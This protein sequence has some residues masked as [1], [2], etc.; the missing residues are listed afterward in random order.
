MSTRI[1]VLIPCK[2]ERLNIRPCIASAASLA[3]E[4]LIADAGSTDGTLDIVRDVGG[5]RIIERDYLHAADFKNWAIPQAT[6]QWVLLVDADERITPQLAAEIRRTLG[7]TSGEVDA[8]LVRRL[9]HYLG[10]RIRRCG[11]ERDRVIRLF[12]RDACRYQPRWVHAEIDIDRKRVRR[13]REPML[14]YATWT[15]DRYIEQLN[16]DAEW[17]ALNSRDQSRRL[18][19]A[20]MMVV[21]PLRFLHLYL[22]KGGFLDGAPGFQVCMFAAFYSFLTKA[23]QWEMQHAIPQP[24]PE[25][26]R[27]D[28]RHRPAPGRPTLAGKYGAA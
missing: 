12:R 3:D 18:S 10:R 16:R 25:A 2:N 23:K 4:I 26:G 13:L 5:C 27:E 8:Y 20:S 1:T 19:I 15:T 21:A 11:W 7:R 24:D 28:V 9:D 17:G 6:H 14:R 22:L